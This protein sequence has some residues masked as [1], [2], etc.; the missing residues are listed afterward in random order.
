MMPA[1]KNPV[2]QAMMKSSLDFCPKK[3]DAFCLRC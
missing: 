1:H 3:G 2:Q